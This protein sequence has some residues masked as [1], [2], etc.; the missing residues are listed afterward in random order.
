MSGKVHKGLFYHGTW[1]NVIRKQCGIL[2]N[3]T[4]PWGSRWTD[5]SLLFPLHVLRGR[6]EVFI[7]LATK[8]LD[9]VP[10]L[11]TLN[12][13]C[14]ILR[15]HKSSSN[16]QH[17]SRPKSVLTNIYTWMVTMCVLY[18]SPARASAR[19]VSLNVVACDI[20]GSSGSPA[21]CLGNKG[22]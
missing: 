19:D 7:C 10:V 1:V 14:R 5:S 6:G 15:R 8:N 18:L 22:D 21:W 11:Q 4:G 16:L 20:I 12:I 3:W 17:F 2:E 13:Y 9:R